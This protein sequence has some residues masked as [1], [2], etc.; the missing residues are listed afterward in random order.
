MSA[1]KKIAMSGGTAFAQQCINT[2]RIIAAETVQGANSGHP[3]APMGCAPMAHVLFSEIMKFSPSNPKWPSRDRFV[4]SNGHACALQ[5][6]MLH[7]LGYNVTLDD[8]KN[9]RQVGSITPGHPEVGITDGVEVSTGPLGQGLSNAVGL[10]IAETHLAA[11]FNKPDF[12]IVDNFTYVIC[13]DGCLQE[14]VTSEA[15]S[16]AGHL[17]LGKLIVLYDDNLITID[18][19][20]ELSFSEDVLKRYEAYGW[21]TQTVADGNT[22]DTAALTA[23]IKAAQGVTDKPSIIKVRTIIGYGAKLQGT[24]KVHGAPLGDDDIARIKGEWGFDP[25]SKFVIAPDVQDYY[26]RAKVIGDG[27]Q[28]KWAE[29]FA[30]YQAAFPAEAAEFMRTMAGDL[31]AGWENALPTFTPADKGDA[32]RKVSQQ[33]LEKLVPAV[34]EFLGGSADLTPSNLTRVDGN[35]IDYSRAARD[36]RYLRFGVREHG[37]CAVVNGLAAYGGIIPFGSTFVVFAGYALGAMRVAALSH[38]RVVYIYTHDSIGLGED[39]PTHQPIETLASLRSIPNFQ[40][41]RPADG[42][43]TSGAYKMALEKK[44]GPTF[45]ALSRQGLPNLAGS[46]IDAVAKGAYVLQD[47]DDKKVVLVGSGSEVSL[48]VKAA[49]VLKAKGIA[50]RVVSFPCWDAFNAQS[51]EYRASVFPDGVPVLSVE[52]L[53]TL[54]WEKYAHAHIGMTTFGASGKGGDVMKHFG[55]SVDNVVDKATKLVEFYKS[56][57]PSLSRPEF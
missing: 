40:V 7:L 20:T 57:A 56:G 13:G 34:P 6:T 50:S 19:D 27:E 12:P 8:L 39:G 22:A 45:L 21:H 15:S 55:F 54:G 44:T 4:L 53:S 3:G 49:D 38:F 51:A 16:L 18:G 11:K 28:A 35:S 1:E 2:V 42:N 24:G 32:T 37:M 25:A 41:I 33:V 26:N 31:P 14:G 43:E 52:A 47:A 46:S 9:F 10:A 5:Y 23:A 36:G 29:M 30:K 48:C 17:G